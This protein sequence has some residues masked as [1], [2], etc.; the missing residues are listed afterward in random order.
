MTEQQ[1]RTVVERVLRRLQ[2]D[3]LI[4]KE[5]TPA[6]SGDALPDVSAVNIRRVLY[7]SGD[8]RRK[9]LVNARTVV[10]YRSP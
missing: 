8:I 5:Q 2:S 1:I 3:A 7:E 9:K 10:G 4:E 6:E